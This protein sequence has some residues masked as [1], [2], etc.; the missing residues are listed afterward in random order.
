MCHTDTKNLAY[1]I[2][3]DVKHLTYLNACLKL[4]CEE[5][6]NVNVKVYYECKIHVF[7]KIV[8]VIT[9]LFLSNF[10]SGN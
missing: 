1:K 2:L 7:K 9:M 5:I 6:S 3:N 10:I 8:I 4:K